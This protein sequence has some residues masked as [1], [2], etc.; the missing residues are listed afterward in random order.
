MKYILLCKL[1]PYQLTDEVNSRLEKGWKLKGETFICVD[2]HCYQVMTYEEPAQDK[3][4]DP[5]NITWPYV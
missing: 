2:R 1:Q 3:G 4:A 5:D